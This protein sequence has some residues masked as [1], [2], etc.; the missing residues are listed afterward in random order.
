METEPE[1]E[2]Q[3]SDREILL[4]LAKAIKPDWNASGVKLWVE[5]QLEKL[6]EDELMEGKLEL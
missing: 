4:A 6:D 1:Y 2:P 5:Y 3:L